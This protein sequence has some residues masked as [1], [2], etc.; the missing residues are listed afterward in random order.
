MNSVAG[1]HHEQGRLR[2]QT[3]FNNARQTFCFAGNS[4]YDISMSKSFLRT[5]AESVMRAT[6]VIFSILGVVLI[7]G[8]FYQLDSGV[9]DGVCNVAVLPIE[10]VI[11]PYRGFE[12]YPF[13]TSPTDVESFLDLVEDEAGIEAVI[14]E[15]NTPGGTPV[16]SERIAERIYN[17]KLPIV[18]LVGDV[19]A[20]GGY[21][22]A[23]A[24][25]HIV[26]SPMSDVG[27]IGVNMSY[28]EES[29]KN[30]EEGLTYVQ[31]IAG[32]FKDIGSPNR[33][34]TDEE[35]KM[36]EADLQI[37]HQEFI[38]LVAKYRGQD[39]TAIE[40]LADG[41]GMPGKRA[42]EAGLIDSLGG[43]TQ[44]QQVLAELLNIPQSEVVFCEPQSKILP[45]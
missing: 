5:T 45:L 37:V 39:V 23:A 19:A 9:G 17:S 30:E 13:I 42:L 14:I 38:S 36:L 43:R 3:P 11:L 27:S 32:K 16:A 10:G 12:D 6:V 18:G 35:R 29:K 41:A 15:L 34:I 25:D 7:G 24:T 44:A 8:F 33:P 22:I 1:T 2:K 21:L 20:S 31:L 40:A 28:V 4:C 26:A